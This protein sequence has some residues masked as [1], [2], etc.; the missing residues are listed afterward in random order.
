[1]PIINTYYF[2]SKSFPSCPLPLFFGLDFSPSELSTFSISPPSSFKLCYRETLW[3]FK[4]G[5]FP[6]IWTFPLVLFLSLNFHWKLA[7][8]NGL[9]F[10]H[11][12]PN[13]SVFPHLDNFFYIYLFYLLI[14]FGALGLRCCAWGFSSCGEQGLLF[15]AVHRLLIRVASLAAEHGL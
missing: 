6:M 13:S 15:I 3:Y 5:N 11:S 8:S 4:Q 1:M 2:R 9:L 10:L 12:L 7:F 14:I